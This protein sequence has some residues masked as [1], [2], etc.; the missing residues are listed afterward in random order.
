MFLDK[1]KDFLRYASKEYYRGFPIVDDAVFDRLS[2]L[3]NYNEVGYKGDENS[4][5]HY[6]PLY[7]LD[8]FY[9]EV[10]DLPEPFTEDIIVTPK[11]DGIAVSLL[12]IGGDL[13]QVLTRGDGTYGTNITNKVFY[14]EGIPLKTTIPDCTQVVGE[15]ITEN[16]KPNARNYVAG[17]INLKDIEE[18]KTR[19]IRFVAHGVQ[20]ALSPTYQQDMLHLWHIGFDTVYGT[21]S[22]YL[23]FSKYK[24]D[25]Q[26]ARVNSNVRFD[27]LGYTAHH[28]R[29]ALAVKKNAEAVETTLLDVIW[30][31]GKSG[32]VTPVAIL[33]PVIIGEATVTRATLNNPK[34]IETLDLHIGDTVL[35]V[36]S[37][38]IIPCIVGKKI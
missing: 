32:R 13:V 1:I 4:A 8:K 12:Y 22:D 16:D 17:A 31:V 37:G 7:S 20:P 15:L 29:G 38:D 11:L 21:D 25:G 35:V 34:F 28:P 30:N 3:I 36:R 24:Q 2:D 9:G 18:F 14:I 10:L 5:K 26:V 27:E 6:Y 23:D 33:E 19:K